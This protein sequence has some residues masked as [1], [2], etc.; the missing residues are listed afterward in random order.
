MI[1]CFNGVDDVPSTKTVER[2]TMQAALIT[3]GSKGLG[4][5]LARSLV[6]DGWSVVIDGRDPSALDAAVSAFG[7]PSNGQVV[8]GIAGDVADP[9]H[10]AE[11]VQAIAEIGRLD[12]V[13]NNASILGPSPQ[14]DARRLPARRARARAGAST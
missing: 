12:L 10:R 13:V 5:A 3:G 6:Q 11:L 8:R 1:A 14:P 9:A 2:I 7:V 4:L